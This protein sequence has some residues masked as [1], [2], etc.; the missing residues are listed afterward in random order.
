MPNPLLVFSLLLLISALPARA[1]GPPAAQ[2]SYSADYIMETSEVAMRGKMNVMPGKERREDFIEDG[3]TMISIRRDDLGKTWILL[4]S[5]Q[6]YMEFNAGAPQDDTN[7]RAP[8][9]EDYDTQMSEAGREEI[10]GL[11]TNKSKVIMTGKDGSKMGGFWWTTDDGIL[12]KMDVIAI[13]QGEKMRMKRELSNIVVEPQDEALFE[14]PEGYNSLMMG[15]GAGMLG[16]PGLGDTADEPD[17]KDDTT[18]DE[19]KKSGFG[20]GTLKDVIDA[21][22]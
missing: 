12:V 4:P 21:V 17:D 9:P 13:D 10:N 6:M 19:P 11:M 2:V 18:Q 5:E 20:L 22:N 3:E 14:I 15:I 7:S 16:I 8:G 1:E